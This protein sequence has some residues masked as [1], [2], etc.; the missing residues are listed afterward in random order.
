MKPLK[1]ANI[2]RI[3]YH[4]V[5]DDSVSSF[6]LPLW[7]TIEETLDELLDDPDIDHVW[8]R[9]ENLEVVYDSNGYDQYPV[10]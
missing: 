2:D 9:D 10:L 5:S 6:T 8:L 3:G 7:K 4:R 1:G